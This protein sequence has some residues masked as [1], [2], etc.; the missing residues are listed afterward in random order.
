MPKGLLS[1]EQARCSRWLA[2]AVL[3]SMALRRTEPKMDE[4]I[5]GVSPLNNLVWLSDLAL[6]S[7]LVLLFLYYRGGGKDGVVMALIWARWGAGGVAAHEKTSW[8]SFPVA[9]RWPSLSC[10]RLFWPKGGPAS[11]RHQEF[12]FDIDNRGARF[13]STSCW[14]AAVRQPGVIHLRSPKWLVPGG[15]EDGLVLEDDLR[16]ERRTRLRSLCSD[17][18]PFCKKTRT[19]L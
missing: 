16:W 17:P 13:P 3:Q 1:P 10:H 19:V 8:S 7:V 2:A 14:E 15:A 6:T 9:I 5:L 18:G 12:Y 11:W 4:G